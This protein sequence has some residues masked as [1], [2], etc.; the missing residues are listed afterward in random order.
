MSLATIKAG[1]ILIIDD[2][3]SNLEVL[4]QCLELANFSVL[5]AQIGNRGLE[6]AESEQ[7]DLILLDLH[8]PGLDGY[9]LCAAL[10]NKPATRE[11][12][13]VFMTGY[14][15]ED[16]RI[17]CFEVGGVDYIA[18]P[19]H[20]KEMLARIRHQLTIRSLQAQLD[21]KN[22]EL[23]LRVAERTAELERANAQLRQEIAERQEAEAA[24]KEAQQRYEL[25]VQGSGDGIWDW[26][27]A[28][29]EAYI[30]PRY[31]E[32]L[33]YAPGE[34]DRVSCAEFTS[35]VHPEDRPRVWQARCRHLNTGE[36][37]RIEYRL[38]KKNGD[39]CWVASRGQV[40]WDK[41]G[42]PARM[43]GSISDIT[44]LKEAEAELHQYREELE[45]RVAERT[46]A[47]N[48]ANEHLL[49]EIRERTAAEI[50]LRQ[51]Q[52][53]YELAT[54]VSGNGIWDWDLVTDR[55]YISP[56]FAEI[57]GY[58]EDEIVPYTRE[59]SLNW[60]H[61]EDRERIMAA[62]QAHLQ[63]QAPYCV[64]YRLRNK[65][66]EYCWI[67]SRG[68]ATWDRNG[69]PLRMAGS[70]SDI[71]RL[72]Q[73]KAAL[74]QANEALEERVRERTA[75]LQESEQRLKAILDNTTSAIY[76]KDL[77]GRYL[78]VNPEVLRIFNLSEAEL[79]GKS[80]REILQ[81]EFVESFMA[82][83]RKVLEA[84][85]PLKFEERVLLS[86][87]KEHS[88][89]S[90]KAPLRDESGNIYA[91]CGLSTDITELKQVE[92][93]LRESQ[94][95]LHL[96]VEHAPS[97]IAMF[98]RQMRHLAVSRRWLSNY[99][100]N[101]RD[102]I[103]RSYYEI[104]PNLDE[105][106]RELHN[107]ALNGE[108][109]NVEEVEVTLANGSKE[110]LRYEIHP[111]Q[112]RTG[113][114][115]GL[116][117]GSEF[118]GDRKRDR[119]KLQQLARTLEERVRERTA[120]FK[121]SEAKFRAILNNIPHKAWLKDRESRFV[122]VNLP[123]CDALGLKPQELIGKTDDDICSPELAREYKERDRAVIASGKQQ[124][125]EEDWITPEGEYRWVETYK[126][127]I[128]D[129]DNQV[130]GTAGIA[131]DITERKRAE[132]ELQELNQQLRNSNVELERAKQNAEAA[133]QS[134]SDFLAKM[135]HELRTPLNAI[136]GFTQILTR[137]ENLQPDQYQQL[138]IIL[139]S[140]E[141]LLTLIDDILDMS[142]I[143]AGKVELNLTH[144]DFYILIHTLEQMLRFKAQVKGLALSVEVAPE[145][146]QYL[147]AD[148]QKLRQVLINL[149]GNAIKFTKMGF[150]TVRVALGD[151]EEPN[152]ES[153]EVESLRFEVVDTGCGIAERELDGL[154]EAFA[155]S[156]A[157]RY[158]L[159]GGTG[160]GLAI[161]K[162]FVELMGGQIEIDSTLDVGTRV[163]F[164]IK[165]APSAS[166]TVA[167]GQLR[168]RICGL[169]P[170]Q[171]QYRI[172]AVEDGWDNRKLLVELL[173]P[174]G[175]EVLEAS[176]GLE[177]V[178]MWEKYK[179]HLVLMDL[180]MPVM[181]GYEA[182]QRIQ[183]APGGRDIPIIALTA[184]AFESERKQ[185]LA[186]GCRDYLTKP[187]QV[188]ELL[189]AIAASLGVRYLYE[190]TA[191]KNS[192][193]LERP[194]TLTED[195]FKEMPIAW[196]TPLH[197]AAVACDRDEISHL[198]E[199]IPPERHSLRRQIEDAI[200]NFDF[201]SIARLS[202]PFL[203]QNE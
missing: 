74:R 93:Q 27:L 198:L 195:S 79:L 153:T 81:S 155:Q 97:A 185:V 70:V 65:Q 109:V 140:G 160:L 37:Y 94:G 60:L 86:N 152:S 62:V 174:L 197:W 154:F 106:W 78:L 110:W 13:V 117:I 101:E 69:K 123:F 95:V 22:A 44:R 24:L 120:Q 66:G 177:G 8:I 1:V 131:M 167:C 53:R 21:R 184:A 168:Q 102:V 127:P 147:C 84:G 115:G 200:E 196:L 187:F 23:E 194:L 59:D 143:E 158:A 100:L 104:F 144:F 203:R 119:D 31:I 113:K 134:K 55:I 186:A 111:W 181:N 58:S 118:I 56:R 157:G 151:W 28:S 128:F 202:E 61:P 77:E 67:S 17:K 124:R 149:I 87:G 137:A 49:L 145:V 14:D 169:A 82:N 18:K 3:P 57:L 201:P 88:Y 188:E 91:I 63:E 76:V 133:N 164:N 20:L 114:I 179:P 166:E 162:H 85:I 42:T 105:G 191:C 148:E 132:T 92:A 96:F 26:N 172:L 38:R 136:L 130:T 189:E 141:H 30:S 7:P 19:F 83:D 90:I 34:I 51:V 41:V 72:K 199:E 192:Q 122:A 161:S 36:P 64:E 40:I 175:F 80:D 99:Q 142:K 29:D 98:D 159:E 2:N 138:E 125:V 176:N 129:D 54:S 126:R 103:G 25:V 178:Q 156:E 180:Q 6:V 165:I 50:A 183:S 35:W 47:L 182:I 163:R 43:A 171:S 150:I 135:T 12:P 15:D 75:A 4:K 68:Q 71:T 9:E 11:I 170:H 5:T 112:D 121:D 33:G 108:F 89:I 52:E 45:S 16:T 10:K 46:A 116:T 48:A 139:S 190:T 32:I 107:K 193:P 173:L 39:Y 73:T 146:P